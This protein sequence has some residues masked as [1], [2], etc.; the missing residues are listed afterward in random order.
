MLVK[1]GFAIPAEYVVGCHRSGDWSM[2]VAASAAVW[3]A[4]VYIG[5]SLT[6]KP[7]EHCEAQLCDCAFDRLAPSYDQKIHASERM[8]GITKYRQQLVSGCARNGRTLEVAA[9]T[10]ICPPYRVAHAV[11]HAG[12]CGRPQSGVLHK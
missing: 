11:A 4:G 5:V 7:P 3:T 2:Q 8:A 6:Q 10:G 12:C 9:G 1:V